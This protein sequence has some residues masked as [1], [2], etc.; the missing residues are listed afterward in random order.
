MSSVPN[1]FKFFAQ[2]TGPGGTSK[3]ANGDALN[4]LLA[5]YDLGD[6]TDLWGKAYLPAEADTMSLDVWVQANHATQD[7]SKEIDS[8]AIKMFYQTAGGAIIATSMNVGP[9][10]GL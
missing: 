2:P 8:V 7:V 6:G 1:A 3:F 10:I 9:C 4:D 5:D